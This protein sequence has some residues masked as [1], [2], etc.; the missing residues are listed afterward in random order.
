MQKSVLS[1]R[2]DPEI[3]EAFLQICKDYNIKSSDW[4]MFYMDEFFKEIL[5]KQGVNNE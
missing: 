2:I 3:K 1:F 4:L 5:K